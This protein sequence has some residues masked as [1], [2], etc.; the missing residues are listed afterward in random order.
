MIQIIFLQLIFM[1]FG[2]TLLIFE[3][4]LSFYY[5][6]IKVPTCGIKSKAFITYKGFLYYIHVIVIGHLSRSKVIYIEIQIKH[7]LIITE[8]HASWLC[9]FYKWKPEVKAKVCQVTFRLSKDLQKPQKN[10]LQV[11]RNSRGSVWKYPHI[12]C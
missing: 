11:R 3:P 2:K 1:Q 9:R 8:W 6:P 10:S 7:F 4:E 5:H 12:T